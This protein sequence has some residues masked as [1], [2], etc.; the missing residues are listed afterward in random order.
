MSSG[1]SK[2]SLLMV[3]GGHS[4]PTRLADA[5]AGRRPRND[6]T[7]FASR[8]HATVL[9]F[10]WLR[11]R[12]RDWV[13]RFASSVAPRLGR[14]S[15]GLALAA[16]RRARRF[17]A[18]YATGE[19]VGVPLAALARLAVW[20]RQTLIVRIENP[21]Y[22]RSG[23]RRFVHQRIMRFALKRMDHVICRT[24]A[25]ADVL[26]TWTRR[27]PDR[28][29][30]RGQEVDLAFFDAAPPDLAPKAE[31]V[32]VIVSAGLEMRDYATL[33]AACEGLPVRVVVGAGSPWSRDVF[34][35]DEIPPNFEV[36]QFSPTEMRS[37][38]GEAALVVISTL[39]TDRAC[40][41]NVV[42]EGWAM[43]RPVVAA[44]TGLRSTI[45]A[46]GG[47]AVAPGEWQALRSAICEVLSSPV[48]A[49]E[50]GE[51]GRRHAEEHL[52]LDDF[53]VYVGRIAAEPARRRSM[54]RPTH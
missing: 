45:L 53:A 49:R 16:F 28:I 7:E 33:A 8:L 29:V 51:R 38:Y 26:R 1:E 22:G 24:Q 54:L 14:W 5:V 31:S 47:R 35:L 12:H 3:V 18:V 15:D 39:P 41:M 36:G 6:V 34:Q 19:D 4:D 23:F 17:D 37:L 46:A 30:V 40:G 9:D 43:R 25:H 52:S 48:I 2:P 27:D 13:L 21:T 42:A 20:R 10:H 32:P 11:R 44:T 50:M